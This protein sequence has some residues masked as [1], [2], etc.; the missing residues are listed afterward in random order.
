MAYEVS[1]SRIAATCGAS[2]RWET[3]RSTIRSMSSAP[4]CLNCDQRSSYNAGAAATARER[5]LDFF[6]QHL[7]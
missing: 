4:F 5:T 6:R 1:S 3:S 7:G 2:G